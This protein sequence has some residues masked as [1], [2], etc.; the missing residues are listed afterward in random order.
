ML[1]GIWFPSMRELPDFVLRSVSASAGSGRLT[2]PSPTGKARR[3]SPERW[4]RRKGIRISVSTTTYNAH[5]FSGMRKLESVV[6]AR[7]AGGVVLYDGE[8]VVP[9][10]KK[11]S[12][13]PISRLWEGA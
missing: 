8:A 3:H 12:A 6:Q 5:D 7:F 13:V 9:F 4:A 2:L 11:L 10:G 1:H